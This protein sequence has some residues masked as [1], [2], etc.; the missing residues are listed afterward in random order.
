MIKFDSSTKTV[1]FGFSGAAC[2]GIVNAKQMFYS[3]SALNQNILIPSSVVNAQSMFA[4]CSALNQNILIP[5][6]VVN[7][8]RMFFGDRLLN[9]DIYIYSQ[10]L[11]DM[12]GMF[13]ETKVNQHN[14]HIPSSVPKDTSNYIYNCLVNNATGVTFTP[15][16]VFNDLPSDPEVWPPIN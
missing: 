12:N 15:E 2:K 1:T 4:A 7:A 5:S 8:Q 9:Q 6:S 16:N 10:V 11:N 3:C 13:T 14:V